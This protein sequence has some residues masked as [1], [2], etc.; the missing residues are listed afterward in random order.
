MAQIFQNLVSINVI[1]TIKCE[2]KEINSKE[3]DFF[4]EEQAYQKNY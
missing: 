3:I 4:I 2:E 1:D